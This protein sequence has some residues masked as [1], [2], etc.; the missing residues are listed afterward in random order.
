M[1]VP[2]EDEW[3]HSVNAA[4]E[5]AGPGRQERQRGDDGGGGE[6]GTGE[7]IL[8]IEAPPGQGFLQRC[9]W[10]VWILS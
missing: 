8:N 10:N 6:T 9:E 3:R 1:C 4:G 2:G 7:V 5:Q